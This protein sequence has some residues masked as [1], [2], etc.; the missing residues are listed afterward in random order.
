M[1]IFLKATMPTL[2]G[3]PC[4]SPIELGIVVAVCAEAGLVK[5]SK[6]LHVYPPA[7]DNIS[8]SQRNPEL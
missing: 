4:I 1:E 7:R 8:F 3:T 5:L 6:E 2:S